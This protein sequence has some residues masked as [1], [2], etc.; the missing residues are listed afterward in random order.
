[1]NIG[2]QVSVRVPI[3]NSFGDLPKSGVAGSSGDSVELFGGAA[4]LLSTAAA[5]L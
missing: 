4:R 1:M 2:V 3:F 5:P